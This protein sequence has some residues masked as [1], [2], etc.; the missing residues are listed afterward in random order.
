[1]VILPFLDPTATG[2]AVTPGD[3]AFGLN[4]RNVAEEHNNNDTTLRI[5]TEAYANFLIEIDK[6]SFDT[7]WQIRKTVLT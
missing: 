4:L 3:K 5:M 6:N 7:S 2:G 1:L